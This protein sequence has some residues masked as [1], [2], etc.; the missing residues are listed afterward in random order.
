MIRVVCFNGEITETKPITPKSCPTFQSRSK[1]FCNSETTDNRRMA[2]WQKLF[3][4]ASRLQKQRLQTKISYTTANYSTL[5]YDTFILTI[6]KNPIPANLITRPLSIFLIPLSSKTVWD[7][8]SPTPIRKLDCNACVYTGWVYR[9]ARYTPNS[10]CRCFMV[11]E[12]EI[13]VTEKLN[14]WVFPRKIKAGHNPTWPQYWMIFC[15]IVVQIKV[16]ISDLCYCFMVTT[17]FTADITHRHRHTPLQHS[18]DPN[19]SQITIGYRISHNNT[20]HIVI[21][22]VQ[23]IL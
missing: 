9:T 15:E 4:P 23:F 8:T 11:N 19:V 20:I 12:I 14:V 10:F 16:T 22:Q 5:M 21:L 1:C 7:S 13:S 18:M 17:F 6:K 3:V 2:P